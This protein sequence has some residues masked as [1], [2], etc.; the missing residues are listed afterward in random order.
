MLCLLEVQLDSTHVVL[1]ALLLFGG[2]GGGGGG[3]GWLIGS[4]AFLNFG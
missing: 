3:G 1:F 2:S 4:F